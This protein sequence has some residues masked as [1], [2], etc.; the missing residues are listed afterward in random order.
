[1]DRSKNENFNIEPYYNGLSDHDAQMLTLY[2]PSHNSFK[3]RLARTGR[4]YDDSYITEF[5]MKLSYENWENVFDST[6]D[7]DIIVIFNN[8]LN[9]HLRIFYSSFPL[10]KFLVRSKSKVWFTKGIL[11]SCRHKKYLYLLCK[12][13]KNTVLKNFYKKY[14]KVL[15]STIQL[16][17]KLH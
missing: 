7:Y 9:M 11:I 13:S 8:F 15:T 1:L 5:K 6:S 4:K 12:M 14:C 2:T 16:A 3:P 17:K 10:H